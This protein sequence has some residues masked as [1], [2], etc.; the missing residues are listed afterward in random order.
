MTKKE[1]VL[2]NIE[3]ADC[4]LI[5]GKFVRRRRNEK[6]SS[7]EMRI[8]HEKNVVFERRTKWLYQYPVWFRSAVMTANKL[9]LVKGS[10]SGID[11]VNSE[12]VRLLQCD[13]RFG[14]IVENCGGEKGAF[15]C[16]PF[17]NPDD[18]AG[19]AEA[20]AGVLGC[21]W[22]IVPG[23]QTCDDSTVRIEFNCVRKLTRNDVAI[24][25]DFNVCLV[26]GKSDDS[27][28]E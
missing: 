23:G 7:F 26:G 28:D 19:P 21:V 2:D 10:L 12:C 5:D 27:D 22:R 6:P 1:E 20:L 9:G 16:E 13:E 14:K 11:T 17:I 3:S 24:D 8:L 15:V 4:I 18:V 25:D